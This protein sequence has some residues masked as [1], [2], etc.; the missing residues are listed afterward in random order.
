VP[1][2]Y[3]LTKLIAIAISISEPAVQYN[4]LSPKKQHAENI[5]PHIYRKNVSKT[6][7]FESR[8]T[9]RVWAAIISTIIDITV[10]TV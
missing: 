8:V 9:K 6:V 2:L 7:L 3:S 4:K 1:F 5:I 10:L